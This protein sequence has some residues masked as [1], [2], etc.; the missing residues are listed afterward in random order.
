[1]ALHRFVLRCAACKRPSL[2]LTV[3][4]KPKIPPCRLCGAWRRP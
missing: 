3:D 4:P 1:M 2:L